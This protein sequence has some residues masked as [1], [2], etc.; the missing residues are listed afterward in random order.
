L[1]P[2]RSLPFFAITLVMV[3][4]RLYWLDGWVLA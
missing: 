1:T 4:E 3:T 2:A